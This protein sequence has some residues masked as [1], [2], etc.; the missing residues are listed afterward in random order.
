MV[1]NILNCLRIKESYSEIFMAL[2]RKRRRNSSKD[3]YRNFH[4]IRETRLA[5][6]FMYILLLFLR[7][8]CLY[9][10]WVVNLS[11]EKFKGFFSFLYLV[12][13]GCTRKTGEQVCFKPKPF[14]TFA[15]S[16]IAFPFILCYSKCSFSFWD[17]ETAFSFL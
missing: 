17:H 2:H 12:I 8:I 16:F 10:Y 4:L 15:F 11:T 9:A 7:R 3:G 13:Q 5:S 6:S 14:T 1:W